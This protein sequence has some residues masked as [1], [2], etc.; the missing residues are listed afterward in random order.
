M[1]AVPVKTWIDDPTDQELS[2]LIN[3]LE[4]LALVNNVPRVL[5]EIKE[6]KWTLSAASLHKLIENEFIPANRAGFNSPIHNNG[7]KRFQFE[8][9]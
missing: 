8:D 2:V 3:V 5:R 9:V 6:R 4:K 1:N 7:E